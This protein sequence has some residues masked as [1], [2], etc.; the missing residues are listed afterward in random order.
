MKRIHLLFLFTTLLIGFLVSFRNQK[1]EEPVKVTYP[2]R[3]IRMLD[4]HRI[5]YPDL[6]KE[7]GC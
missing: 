5:F 4:Y 2:E 6:V 1:T 7:D 3:P